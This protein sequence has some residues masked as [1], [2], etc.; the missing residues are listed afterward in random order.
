LHAWQVAQLPVLQQTPST[1]WVLLH[2]LSPPHATPSPP[3]SRQVPFTP[4]QK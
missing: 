3:L 1:Q 2:W 4:V